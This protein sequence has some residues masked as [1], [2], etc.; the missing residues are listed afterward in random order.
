MLGRCASCVRMS[1]GQLICPQ[2]GN[3]LVGDTTI[4]TVPMPISTVEDRP[5]GPPFIRRLALGGVV[6]FGV[7][8][9]LKHL[10]LAIGLTQAN[11]AV[12]TSEGFFGLLVAATLA[13]AVVAGT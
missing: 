1:H 2:C 9:A 12:I 4:P 7:F 11:T 6:L 8:H 3:Q 13:A 5:D 10:T